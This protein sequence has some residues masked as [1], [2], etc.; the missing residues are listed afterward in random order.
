[1]IGS[2]RLRLL[3]NLLFCLSE[4]SKTWTGDQTQNIVNCTI[5]FSSTVFQNEAV[6][7][8][9]NNGLWHYNNNQKWY[10]KL[11][12]SEYAFS[13]SIFERFLFRICFVIRLKAG[14]YRKRVSF[15]GSRAKLL[16]YTNFYVEVLTQYRIKLLHV[17][18]LTNVRIKLLHIEVLTIFPDKT[19][20]LTKLIKNSPPLPP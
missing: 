17:E 14:A 10:W 11:L 4:S 3:R 15:I 2:I 20:T 18:V 6:K 16:P 8:V 1:M 5:D 12:C 9:W 13:T 7:K 19:S